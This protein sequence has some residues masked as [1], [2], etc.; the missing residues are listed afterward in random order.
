MR[1]LNDICSRPGEASDVISSMFMRPI[2]LDKCVKF[3]DP[4]FNHY[5]EISPEAVGG[6]IFDSFFTITFDRNLIMTS[7]PS[8]TMSVWMSVKNLAIL[9]E[10]VFEICE[11]LSSCRTNNHDEAYA[12]Q[13]KNF[14]VYLLI[15]NKTYKTA[16]INFD[17][18]WDLFS[19][20]T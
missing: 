15:K 14:S 20:I 10:T 19:K 17:S 18:T 7:Y 6:S 4:C 3:P 13:C 16:K 1:Y 5:R 11:E 2:A 9:D 12:N 8:M